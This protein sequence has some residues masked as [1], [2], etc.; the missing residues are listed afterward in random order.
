MNVFQEMLRTELGQS[1]S[2]GLEVHSIQMSELVK[3]A[4]RKYINLDLDCM[5][6]HLVISLFVHRIFKMCN[7]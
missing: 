6:Y 3:E 7:Q 1:D 4:T 2:I 5:N